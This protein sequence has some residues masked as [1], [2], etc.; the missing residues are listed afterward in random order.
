MCINLLKQHGIKK[1]YY[2][3][4]Q[5]N[6]WVQKVNQMYAEGEIYVSHGLRLMIEKCQHNGTLNT[7]H[8]PLSKAQKAH[9]CWGARPGGAP[10]ITPWGAQEAPQ[11]GAPRRHP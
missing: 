11:R 3:D 6:L 1:I 5:G 9:I 4:A 8:L 2:S 7:Q 10:P